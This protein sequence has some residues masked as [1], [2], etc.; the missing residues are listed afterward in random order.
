[1]ETAAIPAEVTSPSEQLRL[2]WGDDPPGY[3]QVWDRRTRRSAYLR[4]VVD[5]DGMKGR[6]EVY[7]A[8]CTSPLDLGPESR[9][10][11]GQVH[12]LAGLWL[13]IDLNG[14]PDGRGG[15]KGGAAP[16][17]DEAVDLAH[18]IAPPTFIVHSGGGL[19]PWW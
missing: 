10:K 4:N 1:M 15:V 13:D 18:A 16:S 7:T 3:M 19:Q 6:A 2:C 11:A 17:L 14:S 9:C 8:V 12:A 5:A